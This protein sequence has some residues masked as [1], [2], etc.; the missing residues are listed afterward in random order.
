MTKEQCWER[1]MAANPELKQ[2]DVSINESNVRT[3]FDIVWNTA[4]R[5]GAEDLSQRL[6][7]IKAA[8]GAPPVFRA[9]PESGDPVDQ[10]KSKL[11]LLIPMSILLAMLEDFN[12]MEKK[13]DAEENE[14]KSDAGGK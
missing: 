1:V 10:I 3:L 11:R 2:G 12:A 8:G 6:D 7:E 14:K 13:D 9:E 5:S 4:Y